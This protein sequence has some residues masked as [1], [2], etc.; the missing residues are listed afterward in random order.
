MSPPNE[1]TRL[2]GN[3]TAKNS[4]NGHVPPQTKENSYYIDVMEKPLYNGYAPLLEDGDFSASLSLEEL[5][6]FVDD[7]WWQKL[8]RT[9]FCTFWLVFWLILITAC[10]LAYMQNDKQCGPTI[11]VTTIPTSAM[12]VGVVQNS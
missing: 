11:A 8:R 7:P 2:L 3:C 1:N 5:L 10:T 6:P 12:T 9:L 4:S